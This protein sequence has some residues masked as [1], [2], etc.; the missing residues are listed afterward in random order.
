MVS[1]SQ[2][3]VFWPK[4]TTPTRWFAANATLGSILVQPTAARSPVDTPQTSGPKRSWSKLHCQDIFPEAEEINENYDNFKWLNFQYYFSVKRKGNEGESTCAKVHFARFSV[5]IFEIFSGKWIKA[6]MTVVCSSFFNDV[7]NQ[8]LSWIEVL[9]KRDNDFLFVD[10]D[11]YF[12][13]DS[14]KIS[15][16]K[17]PLASRIGRSYLTPIHR[18]I[19]PNLRNGL[20]QKL[21]F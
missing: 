15:S 16:S 5:V 9:K 3:S 12:N 21:I 19:S 2:L 6:E 4:N 11:R 20:L 14:S 8:F 1:L 18:V 13:F 10:Q 17:K 7:F